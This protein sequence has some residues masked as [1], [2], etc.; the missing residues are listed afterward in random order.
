MVMKQVIV[1]G[2]ANYDIILRISSLPEIGETLTAVSAVRRAGGKGANQA[3]QLAKLGI[4]TYFVGCIG[5]DEAGK[6][7]EDELKAYGVRTGFLRRTSTGTGLGIVHA[8]ADGSVFATIER[9]ANYHLKKEDID[10][11]EECIRKS[12]YMLLQLEVPYDV[13]AYA[14]EKAEQYGVKVVLNA[15]PAGK[16]PKELMKKVDYLAV[17]EVE[18]GFY[19]EKEIHNM[20]TAM[21]WLPGYR[22]KLKNGMTIICTLGKE[23]AVICGDRCMKIPAVKTKAVETTGAGDSFLGGFVYALCAGKNNEE[24]GR[25]AAYC[26][27]ETISRVGAQEAMPDLKNILNK[28]ERN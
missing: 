8:L 5:N 19:L 15:A 28:F 13:T 9:G 27:A 6:I 4:P 25:F 3:V 14:I 11:A 18:A 17:N 21:E 24:A 7:I 1:I 12:G 23:G 20:E 2:S 22:E 26:S 16:L 10:A